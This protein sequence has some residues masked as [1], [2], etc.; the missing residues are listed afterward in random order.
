MPSEPE[1]SGRSELY[2]APP[3][4]TWT[5][6]YCVV[7]GALLAEILLFTVLTFVYR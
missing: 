2:A 3:F 1:V 6:L 7:A 5:R 4:L